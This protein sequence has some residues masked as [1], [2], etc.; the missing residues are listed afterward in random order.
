[1]NKKAV[2]DLGSLKLKLAIFDADSRRPLSSDSH[3]ILLGKGIDEHGQISDE[4]MERLE[5]ALKAVS[6]HLASKGIAD[7][8]IIG[9]DALRR[10]KNVDSVHALIE[11]Y[12]PNHQLE[13]IDQNREAELFFTAVSRE[14]PDQDIVAVDIGGGSV[15]VIK[16][17]FD[18]KS[19]QATIIDRHNLATGTYRLQQQY[20]PLNDVV[21]LGHTEARRVIDNA[22]RQ[23]NSTAP[24]MVFGSTCMLDFILA[25][26]I[27]VTANKTGQTHPIHVQRQHLIDLFN[28]LQ[29]LAPDSR[30]SYYPAGGYFMYGAD[31]L[32]M[33]VLAA[34]ERVQPTKIYPTNL[35]SSYAFI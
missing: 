35:N 1:M 26:G 10:A 24:I 34:I 31:Y 27:P 33:N 15:Q 13:I 6:A 28:Q 14:F 9:T 21:S 25:S 11:K 3:L 20:S 17:S 18:S 7:I 22:F 16:G 5:D 12:F 19:G 4:S 30:N 8:A 23:V 2:I 29:V 32:L